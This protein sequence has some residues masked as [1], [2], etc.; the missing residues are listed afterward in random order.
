MTQQNHAIEVIEVQEILDRAHQN[1]SHLDDPCIWHDAIE[2]AINTLASCEHL[3]LAA[4]ARHNLMS[5][6]RLGEL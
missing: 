6:Q 3:A 1:C 5:A 4:I 2:S